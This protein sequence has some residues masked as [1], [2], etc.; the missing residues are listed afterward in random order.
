VRDSTQTRISRLTDPGVLKTIANNTIAHNLSN[1]ASA[2]AFDLF[3]GMIPLL[4]MMGWLAGY[5]ARTGRRIAFDLRLLDLAPGPAADVARAH[6]SRLDPDVS[7]LA[8]IVAL[9]F[10]W[11]SS[12]GTH[13]ALA[14]VRGI[15]GLPPRSYARTRLL[16]LGLTLCAVILAAAASAAA[17]LIHGLGAIGAFS[18]RE[19]LVWKIVLIA[20]TVLA[21]T[22]GNATLYRIASGRKWDN[23]SILPGAFI[24]SVVFH[25]VSWAFSTYVRTLAKY[26]AFYGGLAGVAVLLIWLW[27]SSLAVLV[28]AEA[29]AVVDEELGRTPPRRSGT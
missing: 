19:H 29:N 5:L 7:T 9:G 28:G 14:T 1:A 13:V 24:A 11:L 20:T 23:R 21:M 10:L 18:E 25:I 4:A 26:T 22:F 27:L 2:M 17:V 8:P 15:V 6:L 12:S 3:L 16:A